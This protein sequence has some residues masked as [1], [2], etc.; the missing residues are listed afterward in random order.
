LVG[1]GALVGGTGVAVGAG[2]QATMSVKASANSTKPKIL[3]RILSPPRWLIELVESQGD[4]L[5]LR[6]PP[7]KSNPRSSSNGTSAVGATGKEED[8]E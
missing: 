7:F 6:S 1:S 4:G 3:V 2:A 5:G 8:G